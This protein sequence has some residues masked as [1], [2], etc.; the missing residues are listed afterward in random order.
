[1]TY[2]LVLVSG[3]HH[4]DMSHIQLNSLSNLQIC[5]TDEIR[6]VQ[7]VWPKTEIYGAVLSAVGFPGAAVVKNLP[8]S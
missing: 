4:N 8:T 7:V 1:M 6:L 3:V 5:R 2:N